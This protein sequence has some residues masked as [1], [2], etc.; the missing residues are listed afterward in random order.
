MAVSHSILDLY[1]A[2]QYTLTSHEGVI[3][4]TITAVHR[5]RKVPNPRSFVEVR[6]SIVLNQETNGMFATKP[7]KRYAMLTFKGAREIQTRINDLGM[8]LTQMKSDKAKHSVRGF[9]ECWRETMDKYC[10]IKANK[11]NWNVATALDLSLV[12]SIQQVKQDQIDGDWFLV[13][14]Q[15]IARDAELS[16]CYGSWYWIARCGVFATNRN[17]LGIWIVL[18]SHIGCDFSPSE[19]Y[20]SLYE[21]SIE[22]MREQVSACEKLLPSQS[23]IEGSERHF[24]SNGFDLKHITMD[25]ID[26]YDAT[27]PPVEECP[28]VRV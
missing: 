23:P 28:A 15:P 24:L 10:D 14:T 3:T 12:E 11:H 20:T 9:L 7:L 5:K 6:P 17:L 19:A 16:I 13:T 18:A 8:D 22:C 2:N 4:R 1:D 25:D 21:S 26:R 27:F